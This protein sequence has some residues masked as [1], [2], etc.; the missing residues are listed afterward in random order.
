MEEIERGCKGINIGDCKI[1]SLF[2]A[3]DGMI[4]LDDLAEGIHS[5]KVL[6]E[7]SRKYGL[8]IN[9]DKSKIIIFNKKIDLEEVEGIKIENS[10][11]YLGILIEN[12]R[13]MFDQFK[14]NLLSKTKKLEN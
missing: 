9:N 6:K 12:K 14:K 4:L 8:E 13:N 1:N 10:F 3:D 5:I 2:Y 7:T 11:E